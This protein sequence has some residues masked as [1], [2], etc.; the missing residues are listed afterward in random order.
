MR[1]GAGFRTQS[2]GQILCWEH[3]EVQ[4]PELATCLEPIAE[5]LLPFRALVLPGG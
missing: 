4:T 1:E 2:F 3:R 5:G